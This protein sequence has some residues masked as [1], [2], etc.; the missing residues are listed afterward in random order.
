MNDSPQQTF[1]N[2]N[3]IMIFNAVCNSSIYCLSCGQ[4]RLD[5]STVYNLDS[6]ELTHQGKSIYELDSDEEVTRT[7]GI[8]SEG[9]GE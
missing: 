1:H 7:V 9:M 4:H 2:I 5:K 8:D 6:E 3:Y